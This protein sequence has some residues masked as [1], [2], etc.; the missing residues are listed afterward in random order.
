[1]PKLVFLRLK[2]DIVNLLHFCFPEFLAVLVQLFV[3]VFQL[4]Q[5]L[6]NQVQIF[7]S[8]LIIALQRFKLGALFTKG[9]L[10]LHVFPRDLAVVFGIE[11]I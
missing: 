1:M 11:H 7:R 10:E 8:P 5:F 3:F 9:T 4:L 6:L 2:C